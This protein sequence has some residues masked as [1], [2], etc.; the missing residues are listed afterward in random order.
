MT[1]ELTDRVAIV[2]GAAQGIGAAAARKLAERGA[3]IVGLDIQSERLQRVV[4]TLPSSL[5]LGVDVT[6]PDADQQ[7]VG[8]VQRRFGR[9]DILVNAAGGPIGAPPGLAGLTPAEWH[10]VLALN[11]DAPLYLSLAVAP[12]MQ[13]Q[14]WGR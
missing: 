8:E 14:G 13:A 9:V 1:V 12:L 4:A 2:S 7:A 5:A 6:D 11:L 3:R 10:R